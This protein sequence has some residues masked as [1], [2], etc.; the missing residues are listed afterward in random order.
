MAKISVLAGDFL[1]GEASFQSGAFTLQTILNQQIRIP[2]KSIDT[3]EPACVESVKNTK[4]ALG[5]G[6]AGAMLLGPVGAVAGYL[7]AGEETEVTFIAKLKDGRK[8]LAVTNEDTYQEI[9]RLLQK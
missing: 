2:I 9:L 4:D 5:L 6:I 7:I 3:L 8:L 1:Q